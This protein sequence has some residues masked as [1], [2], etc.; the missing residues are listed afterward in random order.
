MYI[1][2]GYYPFCLPMKFGGSPTIG[3]KWP[4]Y[5]CGVGIDTLLLNQTFRNHGNNK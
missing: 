2:K 5:H 1:N 4:F 3:R